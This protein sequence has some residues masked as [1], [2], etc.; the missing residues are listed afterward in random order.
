MSLSD[1]VLARCVACGDC[2]LWT[3]ALNGSG[4]PEM[5]TGR[6]GKGRPNVK[7]W[8]EQ[9]GPYDTRRRRLINTCGSRHCCNLEHWRLVSAGEVVRRQYA[10]KQR[11]GRERMYRAGLRGALKRSDLPGNPGKAAQARAMRDAGYTNAQIA[12]HFGISK[13]TAQRW[14]SGNAYRPHSVFAGILG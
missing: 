3:G 7:L 12:A 2:F 5:N 11:G 6:F 1:Y 13:P 14:A 10:L 9:K 8:I 4:Y